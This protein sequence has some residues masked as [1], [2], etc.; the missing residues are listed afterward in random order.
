MNDVIEILKLGLPGLVFL[1]AA[2]SYKL[3]AK[4]QVKETPSPHILRSIKHYLYVNVFLAVL[5]VATPIVDYKYF[6][7]NNVINIEAV[8]DVSEL[9]KGVAA[10][11]HNVKYANR[12]LL[13]KDNSTG[14]LV[15]VFAGNLVPCSGEP[16]IVLNREDA[17]NLGWNEPNTKGVVE[18]VSALPGYKFSI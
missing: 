18:V 13:V 11:C 3:L 8:T 9:G 2:F 5:T 12:F 14:K 10:V 7:P 17:I 16:H 1:L 4:E 15:Q 6:S